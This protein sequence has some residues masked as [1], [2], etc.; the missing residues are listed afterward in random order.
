MDLFRTSLLVVLSCAVM[1]VQ[2][3]NFNTKSKISTQS[4]P[5]SSV[6]TPMPVK[7]LEGVGINTM[8]LW[9]R[10]SLIR[11]ERELL[12]HIKPLEEFG[13]S[14]VALISC[15]DWIIDRNCP[16][17]EDEKR[18]IKFVRTLVEK[19][20]LHVVLSLKP[21]DFWE[22][23]GKQTSALQQSLEKDIETQDKFVNAWKN[24]ASELKDISR[25]RLS[26]NLLNE[27]EFELPQV[28]AEGRDLW[29]S[30]ATKAIG[31]I[32]SVTDDRVIILEGIGKSLFAHRG[33]G[34]Y[35]KYG[36]VDTLLKT[37]PFKDIVYG[38]HNYEPIAFLQQSMPLRGQKP[39]VPYSEKIAAGV[40]K[41]A[42][43]L[44]SWANKN[45]VPVILSET[46]CIGYVDGKS[47]GPKNEEDCGKYAKDVYDAY[48]ANG[49]PVTWWALEHAKTIY[50]RDADPG[51]KWLPWRGLTPNPHIFSG[52][53]L[54]NVKL[55]PQ[56][57][58]ASSISEKLKSDAAFAACVMKQGLEWGAPAA[59]VESVIER[60]K[61]GS[62]KH[63][64]RVEELIS[65]GACGQ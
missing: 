33:K 45:K 32:R 4:E 61:Q 37:L 36:G 63:I 8:A 64:G 58:S 46:G 27:P 53:R 62:P 40:W 20:N 44:A 47:E 51:D 15:A 1:S 48:V 31:A 13:F 21:Y 29:L 11:T 55:K 16:R 3:A 17:G 65:D 24:L 23:E 54:V 9:S 34:S 22:V 10:G 12:E 42:A 7:G 18:I 52:L 43:L 2:A 60:A 14:H 5:V 39:G 57:G 59:T 28:T 41:D 35:Y 26:F 56:A 19:T 50:L 30:I 38:V 6:T 25:D 49:M